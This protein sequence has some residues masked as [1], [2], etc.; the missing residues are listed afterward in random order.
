MDIKSN[1]PISM[2]LSLVAASLACGGFYLDASTH[3]GWLP[4]RIVTGFGL[5]ILALALTAMKR[6]T[7]SLSPETDRL[8]KKYQR[9]TIL[10]RLVSCV[11]LALFIAGFVCLQVPGLAA[12]HDDIVYLAIA[13]FLLLLLVM[14][15]IGGIKS[16]LLKTW[17]GFG[18]DKVN[19]S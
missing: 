14:L 13:L 19:A 15:V 2:L 1:T 3:H 18:R 7:Y 17:A 16:S 6:R 9:L 5:A 10:G 12:Y 11:W 8:R 4:G